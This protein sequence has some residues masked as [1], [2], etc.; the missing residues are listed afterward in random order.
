MTELDQY[1]QDR[2][3]DELRIV[4]EKFTNA[5][6]ELTDEEKT[7]IY[8]YTQKDTEPMNEELREKPNRIRPFVQH[9]D[10][11][12]SKVVD[13]DRDVVYRGVKISESILKKYLESFENDELI[14]EPAFL[15]FSKKIEIA[16]AFGT[17]IFQVSV[18]KGKAIEEI[19]YF[20]KEREVLLRKGSKIEISSIVEKGSYT[21]INAVEV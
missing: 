13:M 5:L 2:L 21:Y 17:V 19:S 10:F 1:V 15:S 9:L 16:K 4:R 12:L 11:S 20:P 8:D 18:F 14:I 3:R 7:I 6:N